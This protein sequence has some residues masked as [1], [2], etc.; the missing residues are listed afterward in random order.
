MRH[1]VL[2]LAALFSFAAVAAANGGENRP[3][4]TARA[5]AGSHLVFT[6]NRDG[7]EDV[8]AADTN[9]RVAALTR[10]RLRDGELVLAK[11]GKWLAVEREYKLV[12]ISGDGRRE[13]MLGGGTAVGFSPNSRLLAFSRG[14]DDERMF[15][16]GVPSGRPR[17]L[18]G[19]Y[20]I[21]F[22]PSGRLL[23]FSTF[24]DAL[25]VVDVITGR[26][27][28][29]P[30]SQFLYFLGWSRDS[31]RLALLRSEERGETTVK[32]LLVANLHRPSSPPLTLIRSGEDLGAEW[33]TPRQIGF[34]R[35]QNGEEGCEAGVISASGGAPRVIGP[36]DCFFADWSPRGDRI[37]YTQIGRAH[38]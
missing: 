4:E 16:V 19:G 14:L 20:P 9:G 37:A 22:S 11:N 28:I 33:L 26:R 7:D 3:A 15:V 23:A 8:Y 1:G 24:S 17:A 32:I 31:T 25:G 13:R 29:F 5:A 38:V 18:G 36:A 6:S 2:L 12:L 21:A 34:V 35:N 10:N 30:R 27:T